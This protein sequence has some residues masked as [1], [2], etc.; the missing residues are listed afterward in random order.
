MKFAAYKIIRNSFLL[1]LLLINL[2]TLIS[3]AVQIGYHH[4]K[5]PEECLTFNS[6]PVFPVE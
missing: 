4:P 3:A 1:T 6:V 5:Q 2:L